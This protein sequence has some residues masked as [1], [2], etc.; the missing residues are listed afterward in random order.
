MNSTEW[1]I[2]DLVVQQRP[3]QLELP[4]G[5]KHACPPYRRICLQQTH[6]ETILVGGVQGGDVSLGVQGPIPA[7]S[8]GNLLHLLPSYNI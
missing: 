3:Q 6:S 4:P 2:S 8:T 7:S 5:R 1:Q